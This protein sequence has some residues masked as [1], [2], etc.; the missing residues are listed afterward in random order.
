MD[1]LRATKRRRP[2]GPI[3]KSKSALALVTALLFLSTFLSVFQLVSAGSQRSPRQT[4]DEFAP[5]DAAT[6]QKFVDVLPSPPTIYLTYSPPGASNRIR[7][8]SDSEL[9]SESEDSEGT[10]EA[11]KEEKG[12]VL[13]TRQTAVVQDDFPDA[14]EPDEDWTTG[15]QWEAANGGK[16]PKSVLARAR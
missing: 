2:L 15:K 4:T 9:D 12:R 11:H 6:L 16:V 5:L 8:R 7:E 3:I 1:T 14:P 13:E 10:E